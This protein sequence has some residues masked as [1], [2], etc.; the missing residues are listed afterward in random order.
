[1]RERYNL[2]EILAEIKEEKGIDLVP[3]KNTKVSQQGIND[4]FA[5]NKQRLGSTT[6]GKGKTLT[7]LSQEA[8]DNDAE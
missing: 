8:G 3:P 7:D 6:L 4:M 5:K 1:M 2:N